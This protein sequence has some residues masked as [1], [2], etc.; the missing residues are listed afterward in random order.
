[1]Y[2][3]FLMEK[4]IYFYVLVWFSWWRIMLKIQNKIQL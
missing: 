3:Y 1:M 4:V 2:F